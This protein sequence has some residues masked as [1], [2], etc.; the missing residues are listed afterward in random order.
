VGLRQH[1]PSQFGK[2]HRRRHYN[3]RWNAQINLMKSTIDKI[4]AADRPARVGV[5]NA[6]GG[7][8]VG[9]IR[10]LVISSAAAIG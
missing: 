4:D 1:L 2:P 3:P 10:V 9:L 6:R 7:E 8:R 5:T